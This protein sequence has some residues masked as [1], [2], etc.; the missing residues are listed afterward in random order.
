MADWTSLSELKPS[1][2]NSLPETQNQVTRIE[3]VFDLIGKKASANKCEAME[4]LLKETDFIIEETEDESM[5]RDTG[6][7]L[8]KNYLMQNFIM[9]PRQLLRFVSD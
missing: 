4:G 6:E 7:F 9:L 1:I 5:I 8:I 3:Q 2:K